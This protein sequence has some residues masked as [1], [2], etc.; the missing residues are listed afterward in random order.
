LAASDDKAD[1]D[2]AQSITKFFKD[3]PAVKP[4]DRTVRTPEIASLSKSIE[5]DRHR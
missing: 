2:L 3:M 1:R 5:V 4:L